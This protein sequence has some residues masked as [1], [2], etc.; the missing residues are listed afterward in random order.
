MLYY[1][2]SRTY[3]HTLIST[4]EAQTTNE[5]WRRETEEQRDASNEKRS[6][7]HD[8]AQGILNLFFSPPPPPFGI[9]WN[10]FCFALSRHYVR[11]S[12]GGWAPLSNIF[13][14]L[15]QSPAFSPS[16]PLYRACFVTIFR[17]L[18]ESARTL[19][20]PWLCKWSNNGGFTCFA[21][22]EGAPPFSQPRPAMGLTMG[23]G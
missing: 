11:A 14:L 22:N 3:I 16:Y 21:S 7:V 10:G 1:L 4:T 18:V 6:H 5:N 23:R 15:S 20:D 9:E 8:G 17:H 13:T 12:R 2:S 19:R